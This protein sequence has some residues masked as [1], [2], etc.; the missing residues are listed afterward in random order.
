MTLPRAIDL[1]SG[2]GGLTLGAVNAG[3]KVTHA[4]DVDRSAIETYR[5]NFPSVA[6]QNKT[7]ETT[8]ESDFNQCHGLELLMAGPPCQAFSTSNQKT[9]NNDNPLNNLLFEPV[10]IAALLHP[11][12]IMIENVPG[13]E[14][15]TRKIYLTKLISLLESLGYFVTV[16]KLTSSDFGVPQHRTRLFIVAGRKQFDERSIDKYRSHHSITAGEAISDLPQLENGAE[17]DVLPYRSSPNSAYAEELRNELP[18]C[19]GHLVTKNGTDV[20]ERY[21]FIP[22]G[23]NWKSIPLS[24]MTGYKDCSRC[25]TGIYHRIEASKPSKVLGNFRK[26]MLIHP[27]QHRGISIRE[28]A[29]LQSFPDKF[30]FCGSIGKRQQQAG[31]AVP[32]KLAQA[33]IMAICEHL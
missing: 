24:L 8:I 19:S 29:R 15:G 33:M 31:N 3:L 32:P 28:A 1:F 13:L 20:I 16:K 26:N 23:G 9:R 18:D 12:W 10:R 6:M 25:H 5:F 11:K 17:I 27:F 30:V 4:F 2:A 7:V 14:I 22:E 21:R